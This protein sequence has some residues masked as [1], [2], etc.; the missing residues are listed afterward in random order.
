MTPLVLLDIAVYLGV[1]W[2]AQRLAARFGWARALGPATVCYVAGIA[3][4]N[5]P[6]HE[7]YAPVAEGFG[8]GSAAL[9]I[10]LLL[11]SLDVGAWGRMAGKALLAFGVIFVA[12][13]VA[14]VA[15]HLALP[16]TL[17]GQ[18]TLAGMLAAVYLGVTANMAAVQVARG[19]PS[20]LFVN[21]NAADLLVSAVY[22]F[23]V[24][25]VGPR[26]LARVTPSYPRTGQ[27]VD[28]GPAD[29][30][31]L[32]PTLLQRVQAVTLAAV[33]CAAGGSTWTLAPASIAMA[34][35]ILSITTLAVLASLVPRVRALPGTYG[36]GHVLLLVFCTATGSLADFG[37]LFETSLPTLTFTCTLI[38]LVLVLTVVLGA[39]LRIDRDT[40]L[41]T[42]V[43]T[44][45]NPAFVAPVADR[46]ENREVV[47]TGIASGLMGCALANYVGIALAWVLG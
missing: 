39:L 22:L 10:P 28:P 8:Y 44:V 5:Q 21:A 40:L 27:A 26:L 17:A 34:T 19:A 6:L 46:L 37:A 15:T 25:S 30:F 9:A 38:G 45:M 1:P 31:T 4:A 35:A 23:V 24:F 16:G 14:S 3:F 20:E 18:G 2:V 32:R 12:V 47:L 42:S 7:P 36:M 11:F 13:V 29:V 41:I 33:L 43:A